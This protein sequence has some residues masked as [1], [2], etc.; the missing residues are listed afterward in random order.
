M[1][2]LAFPFT[3][4]L[5]GREVVVEGPDQ[6]G[7]LQTLGGEVIAAA[8]QPEPEVAPAPLGR[9]AN[10]ACIIG[11][12]MDQGG[13]QVRPELGDAGGAEGV[14][15]QHLQRRPGRVFIR[16]IEDPAHESRQGPAG[17]A[18]RAWRL[19]ERAA[20]PVRSEAAASAQAANSLPRCRHR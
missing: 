12:T 5:S 19:A 20:A 1:A 10:Q 7:P 8:A 11:P 4:F 16:R 9:D 2:I 15:P 13:G 17:W 3:P 6:R 14:L 18:R